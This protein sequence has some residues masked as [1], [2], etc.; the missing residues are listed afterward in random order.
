MVVKI[1]YAAPHRSNLT[2]TTR[3]YRPS[4]Y[5]FQ[6]HHRPVAETVEPVTADM[7]TRELRER[8]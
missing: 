5:V 7:L 4:S 2:G 8:Q 6:K 3:A 1:A